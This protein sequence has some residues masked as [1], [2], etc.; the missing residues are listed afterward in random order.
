MRIASLVCFT[1]F[2]DQLYL[3]EAM[4]EVPA[5]PDITGPRQGTG[6]VS[7]LHPSAEIVS[8]YQ[9]A[10]LLISRLMACSDKEQSAQVCTTNKLYY[11]QQML[12]PKVGCD[13]SRYAYS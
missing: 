13:V 2:A 6:A 7:S 4:E 5:R 12:R 11:E 3:D 10:H 9:H 1:H 8:H